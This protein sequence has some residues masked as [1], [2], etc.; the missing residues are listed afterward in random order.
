MENYSNLCI[1][2]YTKVLRN[3]GWCIVGNVS[4]DGRWVKLNESLYD[5][6]CEHIKEHNDGEFSLQ[7]KKVIDVLS[8]IKCISYG[9]EEKVDL[10]EVTLELTTNCNLA[11]KHC[12]YSFGGKQSYSEMSIDLIRQIAKWCEEHKVERIVLTGGEIFCRKDIYEI[13]PMIHSC[14]RGDI[15]LITNGTIVNFEKLKPL[16]GMINQYNI[17]LDGYDEESVAEI[18]GKNVFS[19]VMQFVDFLKENGIYKICMSCVDVNNLDKIDKFRKLTKELNVKP[20]VRIL[21]LKGR[22]SESYSYSSTEYTNTDES[23]DEAGLTMKCVCN[24]NVDKVFVSTVGKLYACSALRDEEQSF[25][26]INLDSEK[27]FEINEV[28]IVPIVDMIDDCKE[29]KVRYFCSDTC[30]SQ[31]NAIYTNEEVRKLR[32][33]SRKNGYMQCVW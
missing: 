13:I 16:L 8:E 25:G 24:K 10:K 18:R 32:C 22:A 17:S 20:I 6:I 3:N 4:E 19:K 14:F 28:E 7:E 23:I 1:S 31:N 27:M 9:V 26:R 2:S 33:E 11:C 29:C 21:N 5:S 12:S 15:D 30:I